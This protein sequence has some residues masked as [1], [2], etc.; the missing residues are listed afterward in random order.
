VQLV[1]GLLLS[2]YCP[3][4]VLVDYREERRLSTRRM[5]EKDEIGEERREEKR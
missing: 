3:Y 4:P 5:K 2:L 1:V